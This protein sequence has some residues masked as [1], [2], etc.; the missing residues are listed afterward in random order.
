[1]LHLPGADGAHLLNLA[2]QI[3]SAAVS[4]EFA[5][6]LKLSQAFLRAEGAIWGTLAKQGTIPQDERDRL[7]EAVAGKGSLT[8]EGVLEAHRRIRA[9][10]M[11]G[12]FGALGLRPFGRPASVKPAALLPAEILSARF[13]RPVF[14]K[15]ADNED[16][17]RRG[18]SNFRTAAMIAETS[19]GKRGI[20][21]ETDPSH[22]LILMGIGTIGVEIGLQM[23]ALG[24]KEFT[25]I[26]IGRAGPLAGVSVYLS[27]TGIPFKV[28]ELSEVP[29]AVNLIPSNG[30]PIVL[31]HSDIK[32]DPVIWD[33]QDKIQEIGT[34]PKSLMGGRVRPL[35]T[36][37]EG[38]SFVRLV[39]KNL[40]PNQDVVDGL[41]RFSFTS[42]KTDNATIND[43]LRELAKCQ[44]GMYHGDKWAALRAALAVPA[45]SV[46]AVLSAI[47]GSKLQEAEIDRQLISSRL[48]A[49]AV[50]VF[51]VDLYFEH[52]EWFDRMRPVP[53]PQ[54]RR[55]LHD[56]NEQAKKGMQRLTKYGFK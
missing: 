26:S 5:G 54:M 20:E 15:A 3:G 16:L 32:I 44:T 43:V 35:T 40:L 25:V 4:L 23:A 11:E 30:R 48:S 27:L 53:S 22:P 7:A 19:P 2:R 56:L 31:L 10:F 24:H 41:T 42:A 34:P 12:F 1:M 13:K 47:E 46:L 36:A 9:P 21:K 55:E 39:V 49:L 6:S 8:A 37:E 29:S 52:D 18:E 38:I 17:G 28:T 50:A 45:S 33:R 14:I 51:I